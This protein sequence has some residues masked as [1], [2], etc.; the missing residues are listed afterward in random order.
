MKRRIAAG[1][2]AAMM[3]QV[4]FVSA[5]AADMTW[6]YDSDSAAV[7]VSG[8]GMVNDGSPI[9]EYLKTAKKLT[10]K[11]GVTKIDDSVF[12][13]CGDIEE[14]ELPEGFLSIG[15]GAFGFSKSLKKINFPD[16]LERIGDEAFVGCTQLEGVEIPR[17]TTEIGAN[18]FTDCRL[19]TAFA[20][21]EENQNFTSVDGV[22]FTKDKTELVMYPPGNTAESYEI[23]EGTL[24]ICDKAFSHNESLKS[25]SVPDSVTQ[26][27]GYAF[28]FCEEFREVQ[29]GSGV[30]SVGAYAFY[31]TKLRDIL[32]PYGC[33]SIGT[34]AFKNCELLNYVDIP[35]TVTAPG[36]DIFYG[37]DAGLT[38]RGYGD[39]LRV[40]AEAAGKRFEPTVRVIVDGKELHPDRPAFIT[41]GCTMVPMRA[42]FEALGARVEWS[43]ETKTVSSNRGDT[44]CTV[45]I[46]DKILYKNGQRVELIAPAMLADGRTLVPARAIAEAFGAKV[47]WDGNNGLVTVTINK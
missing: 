14:V 5:F 15:K 10:L 37:T 3:F 24:K 11:K 18:A 34:A 9:D 29:L 7:T 8:Y 17:G 36:E 13:D 31:S 33:E 20:V 12:A 28:Y 47:D 6:S 43:D 44:K 45:T 22:I 30:K 2:L 38:V 26:L 32:L 39:A 23:P 1:V 19:I 40:Y 42:I 41:D 46:G 35:A 25:V 4:G 16:T 27:G 21:S